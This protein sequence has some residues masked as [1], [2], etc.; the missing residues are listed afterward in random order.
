MNPENITLE[1]LFQAYQQLQQNFTN[2]QSEIIG[3]RN[4][5]QGTRNEL[6]TTQAALQQQQQ[7][8]HGIGSSGI[9]PKCK[10]P[11]SFKGKG[12]ITSWITHVSNYVGS[13]DPSSAL[14]IAVSYLEGTAHEWWIVF[15]ETEE[16]KAI[17]T[18]PQLQPALIKRF[19]TLNKVKIARDKLAKWRQ[20]KDVPSFN[21]DFQ[22]IVLDIP[23]ISVEEQIDRYTRGLKPYIWKELCT[24]EYT[25]LNDAMRDAERVESAHRRLGKNSRP[26]QAPKVRQ[27]HDAPT[28]M[29]IGNV[30]LK[31][32]TTAERDQCRKEG[33]CFRCRQ[34]GH[35]ASNC[36]KGQGN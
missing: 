27:A 2:A 16:G 24:R 11:E 17:Q 32:L 18:W 19:D 15:R 10:R 1:G 13:T 8:R 4:E 30:Q 7:Q 12:S 21:D 22:R 14:T 35:M 6:G 26:D 36:P 20:I 28:P 29:D 9:G 3:L 31:K 34:K 25:C 23:N 5:L 33:R